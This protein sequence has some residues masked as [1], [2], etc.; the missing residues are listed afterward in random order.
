MAQLI[1]EFLCE[2]IPARMQKRASVEFERLFLEGATKCGFKNL[3]LK[4]FVTPRRLSLVVDGLPHQSDMV[5]EER[6]GPRVDAP[7][8]AI[9]GFLKST[10]LLLEQLE[11]RDTGKGVFYFASIK[12]PSRA[13]TDFLPQIIR[14]VLDQFSWPKDMR[15]GAK[16]RRWVRPLRH[17]LCVFDGKPVVF[18]VMDVG[19]TS[20][21]TCGHRFLKPDWFEIT[22]FDD[23]EK[24]LHDHFVVLDQQKRRLKIQEQITTL[25]QSKNC[26][27][28][29]DADLL[30]EVC[31]L[32]EWPCSLMGSIDDHFMVLPRDVLITVMRHHQRYFA[33]VDAKNNMQPFFILTSNVESSDNGKT[34][35]AG[36]ERVLRARFNDAMFF[37]KQDLN[38]GLD[39]YSKTLNRLIFHKDLGTFADKVERIAHIAKACG[40]MLQW[41]TSHVDQ[42]SP[43][44]KGDL[45]S[46]TVGEFAELQ[47]KMG[48]LYAL[49]AGFSPEIALACEEHYKPLGASDNVPTK[50]LSALLSIA[51]KI[52]TLSGLF[53]L[54]QKP[55]GSKDPYALRRSALAILR[56]VL[57]SDFKETFKTFSLRQLID[58]SLQSYVTHLKLDD[59]KKASVVA[60]IFDFFQERFRVFM[61]DQ[62]NV[63]YD[64]VDAVLS[65]ANDLNF[66]QEKERALRLNEFLNQDSGKALLQGFKRAQNIL[67]SADVSLQGVVDVSLFKFEQEHTLHK[68]FQKLIDQKHDLSNL[69]G[70]DSALNH[71]SDLQAPIN[72]YFEHVRVQDDDEN[73]RKNRLVMLQEIVTYFS[74]MAN[75]AKI[76]S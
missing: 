33:L 26:Q 47:G 62:L 23:Y 24:K 48:H 4:S 49:K 76:E 39:H 28:M 70:F 14:D 45:M 9:D 34:I 52:D 32:V 21:K 25:A 55:T 2:E 31:G 65:D 29:H 22:S 7:S 17:V 6:R 59:A 63:S 30:D 68:Q 66:V 1:V 46:Q 41:D 57:E 35:V 72:A 8:Q 10:G 19:V 56:I 27:V 16:T 51:D 73:V 53:A 36:N 11:T 37:F 13:T 75:F 42:A 20:N 18:D 43:L 44:I 61:R 38:V 71:L 69:Q 12:T 74:S 67:K 15:W 50:P 58:I 54:S 3:S 5:E 64:V 60:E 40:L